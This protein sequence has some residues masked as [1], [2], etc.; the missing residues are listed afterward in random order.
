M[1]TLYLSDLDGTLLNSNE[2]ISEYT[3]LTINNFVKS[4]GCFSYATARSIVTA[5]KATKAS[6][7]LQ[8]KSMLGCE[9]LVMFGDGR[10]DLSLFAV[11]DEK[12]AMSNAVPELKE[13]STAVIDSNNNDGVAKWISKH[14]VLT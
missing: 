11:A 3:A 12:Y 4:G 14:L 2:R 7:A 6:A 1:K 9:K 8:L 5:S 10:N 13:I